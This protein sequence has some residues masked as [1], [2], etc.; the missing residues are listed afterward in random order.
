MSRDFKFKKRA[1]LGGVS[2]LILADIGLAGYSWHLSNSPNTSPPE[3]ADET[4]KLKFFRADIAKAEE[5]AASFP[6]NVQDCDKFEA[7][8]PQAASASSTI[9]ADLSDISK[10]A[11]VQ[12]TDIR[13][14]DKQAEGRDI[15]QREM[16]A[17]IAGQY[18]S[19]VRF[20][21]GLQKS[22]DYYV[23]DS[24]DLGAES[25]SS[26]LLRVKVHM[27]TFFRGTAA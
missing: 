19:V 16:D 15:T 1:I 8:L 2:L 9:S 26:N 10:K 21:N 4:R 6:K 5:S 27:R 3:L 25:S 24:L 11:G 14:S 7:S 17:T 23:V 18:E 22:P 12:L 13:F 20:L